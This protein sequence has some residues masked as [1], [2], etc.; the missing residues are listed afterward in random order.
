MRI[1]LIDAILFVCYIYQKPPILFQKTEL[2]RIQT[3]ALRGEYGS[4][5]QRY[6]TAFESRRSSANRLLEARRSSD[7]GLWKQ[8]LAGYKAAQGEMDAARRES[9]SLAE[10]AGG[11]RGGNDTNYI[12]LTFVTQHLP[13]GL[14]GLVIAVIFGATMAA[15]SAEMN[16]LATVSMVDIYKRHFRKV[17]P[18][19]H[20]LNVSRAATVFW[21]CYAVASAEFAKG[22]GSLVETVNLLGSFF[23]GGMLGVFVLAFFFPRVRGNGAFYGVLAGEAAIFACYFFTGIAFL[24]YNVVGCLTVIATGLLI[25]ARSRPPSVQ[26]A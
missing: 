25:S 19:H 17:A 11:A 15:I 7:E 12:F 23:Y 18:D 16:S 9:M 1:L 13:A 20:F 4:V 24:W 14:V 22:Q 8:A 26:P 10:K 6:D 3:P 21:G 5:A 2:E